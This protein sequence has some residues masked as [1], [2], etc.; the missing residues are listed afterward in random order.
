MLL[1]RLY[2]SLLL[3]P[4]RRLLPSCLGENLL[5]MEP[6]APVLQASQQVSRIWN[7]VPLAEAFKEFD[8][9]HGGF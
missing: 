7:L 6:W 8:K 9:Y 5:D 1:L 2:I 4:V 3:S